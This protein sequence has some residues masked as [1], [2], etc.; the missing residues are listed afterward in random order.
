M[1]PELIDIILSFLSKM[2]KQNDQII[3]LLKQQ[4]ELTGT[5][6][7]NTFTLIAGKYVTK[8]DFTEKAKHE[9]LPPNVSLFLPSIPVSSVLLINDGPGDIGYATNT[10]INSYAGGSKL[11]SGETRQITIPNRKI[12]Y[13]N[14]VA[15]NSDATLRMEV[16]I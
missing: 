7:P 16:L 6:Y 8:I 9:Q 10:T 15:N 13:L 3:D 5:T 12:E 4:N 1:D 2:V 14:V 11:Y